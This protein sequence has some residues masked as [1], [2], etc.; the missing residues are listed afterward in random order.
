MTEKQEIRAKSMELAVKLLGLAVEKNA[1][2]IIKEHRVGLEQP[3]VWGTA[4]ALF[5][6]TS[7]LSKKI[8]TFIQ[9]AL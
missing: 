4:E 3:F 8:E 1:A 2:N 7:N 6:D 9:E 5:D